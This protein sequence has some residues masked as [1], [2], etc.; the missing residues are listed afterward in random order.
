MSSIHSILY[1]HQT[2][3]LQEHGGISRYFCELALRVNRAEGFN[4]RV[5]APIH[6]NE[7]LRDC[8]VPKTAI[9]VRKRWKTGPLYR[10]IDGVLTPRIIRSQA[11]SLIHR[12][13]FEP[14]PR[15][16]NVPVV[17]T[18]FDMINELFP[19]SFPATDPTARK[20]RKCVQSADHILCISESTANDLVRICA[21]PRE[22]ISVTY[23]GYSDI[24]SAEALPNEAAPHGRPYLLYVGHRAGHKNFDAA[25]RAYA[26][27]AR[28][29]KEFDLVAFGGRPFSSAERSLMYDL[30][31][32]PE[33]VVRLGGSDAELARAY[34]HAA[35]LVYP[36]LY[37]GFGIP[38]LEAMAA[39]C[40]VACSNASSIPEVVGSAAALFDPN[41]IDSIRQAL[42][43]TCIGDEGRE[44][45]VAAGLKHVCNFSWDRCTADTL[46]AYRRV[47]GAA[48]PAG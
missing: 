4:A 27:S 2:F 16:P 14:L 12:T 6:F 35:A 29:R 31:L 1:D 36:S 32:K 23:L 13:F 21:V 43:D 19:D 37:E 41:D 15:P 30:G 5:V 40:P 45:L 34:R 17:L 33:G 24:F 3:S 46:A 38:P 22:K 18:V 42:E 44:R 47:L 48:S 7:Y 20:K 8:P 25:L 11:P 9:Y 10:T 26:S 28:L 39:G